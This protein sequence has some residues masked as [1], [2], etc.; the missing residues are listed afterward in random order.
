MS[1]CRVNST[2]P[3]VIPYAIRYWREHV[4]DIIPVGVDVRV[5][6]DV[7]VGIHVLIAIG[8]FAS[9]RLSQQRLVIIVF[10]GIAHGFPDDLYDIRIPAS[11]AVNLLRHN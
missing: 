7:S 2:N 4:H 8:R 10:V 1:H 5:C 11:H 9:F 3:F 6:V